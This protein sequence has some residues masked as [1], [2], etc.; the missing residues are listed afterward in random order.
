MK[1][2]FSKKEVEG[3]NGEMVSEY[4]SEGCNLYK[5]NKENNAYLHHWT[6]VSLSK[7]GVDYF[8]E[9][10]ENIEEDNKWNNQ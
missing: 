6:S 8:A 9:S 2:L 3:R 4:R 5:Y 7:K 10:V 1:T